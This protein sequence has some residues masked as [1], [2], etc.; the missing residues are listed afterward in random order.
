MR[1]SRP[2]RTGR[3]TDS[4][5]PGTLLRQHSWNSVTGRCC[6]LREAAA[7]GSGKMRVKMAQAVE[8]SR[9]FDPRDV[10]WALGHA[11]VHGRF[12]E[13][14][15]ASILDHHARHPRPGQH[16]PA[17]RAGEG[18]SLAQG[19]TSWAPLGQPTHP[20]ASSLTSSTPVTG[21]QEV[22]R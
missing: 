6:G 3:W 17:H 4:R 16:Q 19:T 18:H 22:D 14:D 8:L 21:S 12:A 5:R 9:L 11:A 7:A 1:I 15:L 13:A 20:V 10:D 2:P